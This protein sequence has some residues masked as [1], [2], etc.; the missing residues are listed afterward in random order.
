[1][2]KVEETDELEIKSLK[3]V[4]GE[5]DFMYTFKSLIKTILYFL[6]LFVE[7]DYDDD[8]IKYWKNIIKRELIET[9]ESIFPYALDEPGYSIILQDME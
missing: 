6:N 9:V 7:G 4:Y 3:F 1:M 5:S 2:C 8:Y